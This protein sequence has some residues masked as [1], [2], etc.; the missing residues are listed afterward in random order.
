MSMHMTCVVQKHDELQLIESFLFIYILSFIDYFILRK[1]RNIHNC[2]RLFEQKK[3]EK[4]YFKTWT[5]SSAQQ[6]WDTTEFSM[7]R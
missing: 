4:P 5:N 7:T 1:L 3:F 2:H 6:C